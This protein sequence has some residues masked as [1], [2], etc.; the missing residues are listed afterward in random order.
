MGYFGPDFTAVATLRK[1][2][3]GYFSQTGGEIFPFQEIDSDTIK[4]CKYRL[5]NTINAFN[6]KTSCG[7]NKMCY[8]EN[9]KK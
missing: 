5:F 9:N 1:K 2:M 6:R 7:F 3:G 4:R 8:I